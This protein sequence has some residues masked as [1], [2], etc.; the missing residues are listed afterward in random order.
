MSAYAEFLDALEREVRGDVRSDAWNRVFYSTDAS[1]YQVMP[2]AVLIPE[3]P[4]DVEAAVTVAARHGV[5]V[6]P[7]G[8]GSSL[9]GQAVNEAL[10]I[11]FSR[12]LDQVLELDADAGRVRVQPGV[13]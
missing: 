13:G 5:P 2:I 12:H 7:R 8:S 9:A 4:D 10:V 1:I 11:D 3:S 6:L